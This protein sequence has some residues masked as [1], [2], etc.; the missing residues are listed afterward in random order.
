MAG[1]GFRRRLKADGAVFAG[2]GFGKFSGQAY[3][4]KKVKSEI[5]PNLQSG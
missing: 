3:A 2:I 1:I 4:G 5:Q